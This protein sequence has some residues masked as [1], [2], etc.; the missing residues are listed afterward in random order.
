M[1]D[2]K[3]TLQ[4]A[5]SETKKF[6]N[7][8]RAFERID[9]VADSLAASEQSIEDFEKTKDNLRKEVEAL[10]EQKA[11]AE[12]EVSASKASA[13]KAVKDAQDKASALLRDAEVKALSVHE[14]ALSRVASVER[15]IAQREETKRGI[16]TAISAVKSDLKK[17]EDDRSAL[18]N[19]I[20]A[21]R[22]S[23]AALA[24]G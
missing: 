3:M 4:Q 24:G 2:E 16:E 1:S 9:E 8:I 11:T 22:K 15:D 20:A 6:A 17:L 18:A 5:L 13:A 23:A 12:A 21:L 7:F 10:V 14:E 19:N